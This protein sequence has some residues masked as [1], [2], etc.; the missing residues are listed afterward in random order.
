MAASQNPFENGNNNHNGIK[1]MSSKSDRSS[2]MNKLFGTTIIFKR[3]LRVT[4]KCKTRN[5]DI[6]RKMYIK[7]QGNLKKQTDNGLCC[8][9]AQHSH[10]N[11]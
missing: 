2:H 6:Y 11:N 4:S 3:Q 10:S 8:H 5:C 1:V 9:K 7:G